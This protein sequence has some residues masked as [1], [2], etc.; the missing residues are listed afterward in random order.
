MKVLIVHS[1]RFIL[2]YNFQASGFV[3][4]RKKCNN[5]I[6]H[7]IK[8]LV[9]YYCTSY[10]LCPAAVTL[11]EIWC[12]SQRRSDKDFEYWPWWQANLPVTMGG[13]G[14]RSAVKLTPSAFMAFAASTL[15]VRN[16]MS[17]S[18]WWCMW[19]FYGMDQ[20]FRCTNITAWN[21]V[22]DQ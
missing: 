4:G 21:C 1:D 11:T 9:C 20:F 13:L 22:I 17:R 6:T 7:Q 16:Y 5:Y 15:S 18:W 8:N 14:I 19:H 12:S 10:I 3:Q 2:V